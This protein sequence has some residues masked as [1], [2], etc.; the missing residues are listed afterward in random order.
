NG[1]LG[2]GNATVAS[3]S[4]STSGTGAI[5]TVGTTTFVFGNTTANTVSNGGV[6]RVG[7]DGAPATLTLTGPAIA[8]TNSG[9]IDLSTG[10]VG[11]DALT[12]LTTAFVGVAGGQ[13]A[14]KAQ[15]G[16]I[17]S[18]PTGPGGGPP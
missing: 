8:L 1:A 10:A 5:N 17:G 14:T 2:A 4:V 16:G 11:T 12:G 13:I 7:S 18:S 9:V 3:D 6:I 15:L